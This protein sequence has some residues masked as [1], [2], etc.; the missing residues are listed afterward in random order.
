MIINYVLN[1]AIMRAVDAITTHFPS[2]LID[3]PLSAL[4]GSAT[5]GASSSNGHNPSPPLPLTDPPPR[6]TK[7]APSD[8]SLPVLPHSLEPS[9]IRLNLQIQQFIE[10]FRQMA[11]SAPST[12]SSSISSMT[13]SMHMS[14]SGLHGGSGVTLTNA[15][16]AAQG[17]HSEAK[18]MPA[19]VRAVYLQ[20]IKDVGA[21]FAYTDPETS[22]L[23]GFLEQGRR[24]ALADQVNKAILRESASCVCQQA[25]SER[26]QALRSGIPSRPLIDS[27]DA[28]P[29]YIA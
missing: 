8:H 25:V 6:P 19:E 3:P 1:G 5:N 15:L 10:S 12:P 22:I 23:K 14:T 13:S 7:A 4:N 11:H 29:R 21:L 28:P 18:K 26:Y 17:L 24:I 2:V 16:T 27:P 9:H 20:E